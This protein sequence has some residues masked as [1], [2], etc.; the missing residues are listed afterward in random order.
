MVSSC[1]ECPHIQ[2]QVMIPLE[3]SRGL[4]PTL[5]A[6]YRPLPY[7]SESTIILVDYRETSNKHSIHLNSE[8]PFITEQE[9]RL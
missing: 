9:R 6:L 1:G 5:S 8:L 2:V 3:K 7:R 4:V